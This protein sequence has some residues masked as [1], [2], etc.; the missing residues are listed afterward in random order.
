MLQF[1][2]FAIIFPNHQIFDVPKK[3]KKNEKE[4]KERMK[5][6]YI[7]NSDNIH[8]TNESTINNCFCR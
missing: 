3:T 6:N 2:I 5:Y 7:G 4:R 1:F 8:Y